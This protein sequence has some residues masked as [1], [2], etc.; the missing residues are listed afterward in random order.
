MI[1]TIESARIIAQDRANRA[2]TLI[3]ILKTPDGY[4][5]SSLAFLPQLYET[6]TIESYE[7]VWPINNTL[8]N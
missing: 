2:N 3:Y 5:L 4:M 8:E 6:Y 1:D 7:E